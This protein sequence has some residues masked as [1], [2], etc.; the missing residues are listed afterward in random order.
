MQLLVQLLPLT[1]KAKA[2]YFS[3]FAALH[4]ASPLLQTAQDRERIKGAKKEKRKI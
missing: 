3:S 2:E 1:L 4:T